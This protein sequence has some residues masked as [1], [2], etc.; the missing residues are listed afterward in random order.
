MEKRWAA[1]LRAA[2]RQHGVVSRDQAVALGLPASTWYG[3][4]RDEGWAPAGGGIALAPW[5]V[6]GPRRDAAVASLAVSPWGAVT[7]DTS[8]A[9]HG[10]DIPWPTVPQV[11]VRHGAR[12]ARPVPLE[13]RRSRNLTTGDVLRVDGILAT[14]PARA[15]LDLAGRSDPTTLRERIIDARQRRLVTIDLL[16]RRLDGWRGATG[17]PLLVRAVEDVSRTGADSPLTRAVEEALVA[18]GLRPDPHPAVVRVR[19]RSLHPDITFASHSLAIECDSIGY[20]AGQRVLDLDARKH[21]A[22]RAA[23]WV[24]L[25]ITWRGLHRDL[26][27]FVAHVRRLVT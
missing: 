25:R 7:A 9:L 17:R 3:R 5:S 27:T 16:R 4:I 23:G 10:L 18:A 8:L 24:S 20:H 26:D 15:L 19:G 1:V 2:K 21:N 6:P 13:V 11:V 22:Y 12:A 14:V